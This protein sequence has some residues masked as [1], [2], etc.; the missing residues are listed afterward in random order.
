M[1]AINFGTLTNKNRLAIVN[2]PLT[3]EEEEQQ[4]FF[5]YP[6]DETQETINKY[7]LYYFELIIKYGYY[8]GFYLELNDNN[9][10]WIYQD[11]KEKAE[12]IKELTQI[13][14]ILL[15]LVKNGCCWGCYPSQI[16]NKLDTAETIKQIKAIIKEL[17]AEVKASY[18]ER[19][20]RQQNKTF[21]TL[22]KGCKIC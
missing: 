19:T 5:N 10:K 13:K 1:G 21:L 4:E 16:Y 18:T 11:T 17:K 20:A 15:E 7:N 22:C 6:L 2:E 3:A 14:K 9:T 12:A 8:N